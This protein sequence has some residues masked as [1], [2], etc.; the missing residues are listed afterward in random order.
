MGTDNRLTHL[1]EH[2][3]ISCY[4]TMFLTRQVHEAF[5]RAVSEFLE[6]TK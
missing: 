3:N 1:K 2:S 4:N 6:I 5:Q